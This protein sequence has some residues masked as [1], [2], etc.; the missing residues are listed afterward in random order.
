M[1]FLTHACYP[2]TGRAGRTRPV[3][4]TVNLGQVKSVRYLPPETNRYYFA[5]RNGMVFFHSLSL[6][7]ELCLVVDRLL[8]TFGEKLLNVFNLLCM[9]SHLPS[10]GFH[11]RGL[12]LR[13]D[14]VFFCIK[15][16]SFEMFLLVGHDRSI[17]WCQQ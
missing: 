6:S 14:Y 10:I 3:L 4:F 16:E 7:L 17:A 11:H 8:P 1:P 13:F 9:L 15:K 5:K 2:T 12:R